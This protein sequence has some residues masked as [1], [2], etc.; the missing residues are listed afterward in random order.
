MELDKIIDEIILDI[1]PHMPSSGAW[2]FT[3]IKTDRNKFFGLKMDKTLFAPFQLLVLIRT[4][5]NGKDLLDYVKKS[6]EYK[7]IDAAMKNG[8]LEK[9]NKVICDEHKFHQ[10]ADKTTSLAI[11][12]VAQTALQKGLQIIPIETDLSILDAN[13]GLRTK[14]LQAYQLFDIYQ[15]DPSFLA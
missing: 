11:G 3:M 5:F 13:I 10:W 6:K 9:Y 4:D 8:F 12:L 14:N 7:T 15:I 1:Y 2:P